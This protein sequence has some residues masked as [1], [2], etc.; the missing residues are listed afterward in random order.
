M[1]LFK[2]FILG[3]FLNTVFPQMGNVYRSVRLKQDHNISYTRYIS[4][5]G[6]FAWMDSLMNLT[7]VTVLILALSPNLQIGLFKAWKIL[8]VLTLAVAAVPAL[9]KGLLGT[10]QFKNPRLAW[11]HSKLSEVLM[12]SMKNLKDTVYLFKI[13][14]LGAATLI[15]AGALF[16]IC[17][18]IFNISLSLSVLALFYALLKFSTYVNVTPGNLGVQELAYGFLSEQL[19]IGMA[20]GV[21]ASAFMRVAGSCVILVLGS[22][23]GGIDLLRHR[24]DY[25]DFKE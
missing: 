14:L 21:L 18:L 13:A 23:F 4:S 15:C 24:K 22:F 16:Y 25:S 5:L 7:T 1:P 19:G 8:F 17:F 11:I 10:M 9:T 12:V 6:S 2:I 3:R 20:Q